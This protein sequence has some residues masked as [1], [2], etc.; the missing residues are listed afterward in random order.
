MHG[1]KTLHFLKMIAP[2]MKEKKI[3]NY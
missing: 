1:Y 3:R 2:Y